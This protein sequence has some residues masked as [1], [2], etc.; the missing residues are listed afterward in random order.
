VLQLGPLYVGHVR[1]WAEHAAALGYRV[2]VAGHSKPGRRTVQFGDVAEGVHEIG[3]DDPPLEWLRDVIDRVEPDIV[4]A[5]W[6]PRW[7]RIA[8]AVAE[9]PV[10]VSAW[11]SDVYLATG[12][13]RVAAN[14]CVASADAVL[15]PSDHMRRELVRRGAP[16]ERTH[17]VD[18][19][20]DLERFRPATVAERAYACAQLG[21]PAGPV[22]LSPRA[23]TPLYNLDVVLAGFAQ[24]RGRIPD[25]T[26][27]LAH[28]DLPLSPELALG[29]GVRA[30]RDVP[31]GEMADYLRAATVVISIPSSD[32]SPNSVWEALA[33]GVPVVASDLPQI[34]E[35]LGDGV[36]S[37]IEPTPGAVA[38]ALHD[39]VTQPELRERLAATGRAW[40]QRNVDERREV[41]RLAAVYAAVR[42]ASTAPA[43]AGPPSPS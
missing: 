37:F 31:Q 23:P 16:D 38:Q 18:L 27:V 17:T 2:S 13:N 20:V 3:A 14:E 28:G 34:R 25:A 21:L 43:A 4:H 36:V 32:G 42:T 26:L 29:P 10:V 1:R 8:V 9:R 33:S 40:A 19:G 41:Q 22:V 11:G 7:G 30:A 6:L 15:A 39:L 5:H 12:Q 24:L 35:R